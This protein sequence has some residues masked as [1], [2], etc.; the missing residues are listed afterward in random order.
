MEQVSIVE[1]PTITQGQ[2]RAF[3]K[4]MYLKR[5]NQDIEKFIERKKVYNAKAY[6]RKKAEL[7]VTRVPKPKK[8]P[9]ELKQRRKEAQA[10]SYAKRTAKFKRLT[11]EETPLI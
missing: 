10:K 11:N 5:K 3:Y 8:T 7:A 6:A 1:E 4:E 9:E 2:F